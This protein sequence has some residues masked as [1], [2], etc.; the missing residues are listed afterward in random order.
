MRMVLIAEDN[1]VNRELLIELLQNRGYAVEGTSN[2]QEALAKIR[3]CKPDVVLLDLNMPVLDG[4]ATLGDSLQLPVGCSM[5]PFFKL[6][7]MVRAGSYC[8]LLSFI[9]FSQLCK[10][11]PQRNLDP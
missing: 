1:A 3:E 8:E 6:K 7:T 4:F 5:R 10:Y 11:G 2:G 9:T